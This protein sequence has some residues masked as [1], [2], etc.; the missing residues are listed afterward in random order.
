MCRCMCVPDACMYVCM[1]QQVYSQLEAEGS[2]NGL[3]KKV[4]GIINNKL[5]GVTSVS[6]TL[7]GEG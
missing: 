6:I 3:L 2:N 7:R 5:E 1:V 4:N